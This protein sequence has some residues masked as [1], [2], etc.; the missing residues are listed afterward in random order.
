MPKVPVG[1]APYA[2]AGANGMPARRA[3]TPILLAMVIILVTRD[4]NV[5]P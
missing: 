1:T 3:M 2:S 5:A 4:V